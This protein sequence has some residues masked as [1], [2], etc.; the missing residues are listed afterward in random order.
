MLG[1]VTERVTARGR[2]RS[3]SQH[4]H[5]SVSRNESDQR[6]ALLLP[7]EFK[8]LGS[9]RLVVIAENCKPIL[10]EKIRYHRDKVFKARLRAPSVVPSMDMDLHF[11]KVRQRW[12]YADDEL[13]P[14]TSL[15]IERLADDLHDLPDLPAQP[16]TEDINTLLTCFFDRTRVEPTG[17]A[18]G[19]SIEPIA[20]GE[21]QP[22]D[23][24]DNTPAADARADGELLPTP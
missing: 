13:P 19:G 24:V 17:P 7:Q 23:S 5:T 3:F 2:S 1:T 6:R 14:D 22:A 20:I 8:E 15:S 11:A 9:E 12:R 16:S 4:G 21:D 10:A 18:T